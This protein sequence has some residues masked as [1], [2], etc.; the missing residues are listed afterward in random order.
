MEY[1]NAGCSLGC[2]VS[3]PQKRRQLQSTFPAPGSQTY[4]AIVLVDLHAQR[5]TCRVRR[6]DKALFTDPHLH[7]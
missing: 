4:V 2:A 7:I 6:Y 1:D 5:A 3:R